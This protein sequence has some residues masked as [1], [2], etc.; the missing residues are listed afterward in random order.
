VT[1]VP[2]TYN[3]KD[4]E[5]QIE[6][7]IHSATGEVYATF[8]TID[9]ATGQPP[10][11]D[12]GFLPPE[13]GTGR[14]QGCIS[15]V[16]EAD[17]GLVTGTEIRNVAWI[18][19][20][21]ND[22]IPTNAVDPH[23]PG[24]GTDPNKECVNTVDAGVPTS[25]VATLPAITTQPDFIVSWAGSDDL[26]GSGIAYYDVY[27][28]DNTEDYILWLDNT[29]DTSAI[30][31]GENGH[32]YAFYSVARDNVGHEE[33]APLTSD[34]QTLVSIPTYI[35]TLTPGHKT[36]SWTF[37]DDDGDV[38]TVA[39]GGKTGTAEIVR[40]VDEG[41]NGDILWINIDGTD[42][43]SS[44]V[45]TTKAASKGKAAD[46]TVGDIT[47]NGSLGSI[48]GKNVDLAGNIAVTGSLK[49]LTLDD[50]EDGR[51]IT[52]GA[53]AK[54]SDTVTL[55]FDQV[56]DLV[57]NSATPIKSLTATE[58]QDTDSVSDSVAA[59]WFGALNVKGDKRRSI[60][61]DFEA[62]L[63]TSGVDRKG[64]SLSAAK[65]AG[66]LSSCTWDIK[67]GLGTLAAPGSVTNWALTAGSGVKSLVLGGVTDT[68]VAAGGTIGSI[69]SAEWCGGAITAD[70]LQSLT[71]IGRKANSK[72]GLAGLDGNFSADLLLRGAGTS[73]A[74]LAAA[75]V[76]G[77]LENSLWDVTGG[78]GTITVRGAAQDSI[79]RTTGNI[80]G[81]NLGGAY[82]S[83]FLAG[84]AKSAG[85]QAG[86]EADFVNAGAVI[87]SVKITGLKASAK[88]RFL[89]DSN[90]SAASFGSVTLL[91]A[92]SDFLTGNGGLCVRGDGTGTPMIGSVIH[93]DTKYKDNN[94][95]WKRGQVPVPDC[96][97]TV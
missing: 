96:I 17:D 8:R 15:Y 54:P 5:V 71:V 35:H 3:G 29:A 72:L 76:A 86:S 46:T 58:W 66:N 67:G 82:G 64:M 65:I 38:V 32:T 56:E 34:T 41:E 31:H 55:T 20:D 19:F 90:F 50:V 22:P 85:R 9:P 48:T 88:D 7:G 61:G 70:S 63:D 45:I 81:I 68:T 92:D 12:W 40:G 80:T 2:I 21:E 18:T 42:P 47:V 60:V 87:K 10:E 51:S 26:G 13:D 91:N 69:K 84:V 11:V 95:S 4:L 97:T 27:V 93:K 24:Q 59:P 62:D 49:A 37:T 30:Y 39:L 53:A 36:S 44:L 83:D 75:S 43:K 52:I 25:A 89:E 1:T 78:I 94:W 73:K 79:V 74:S 6:A 77:S 23:D 57:I 28:R 14:G 33:A 16:I